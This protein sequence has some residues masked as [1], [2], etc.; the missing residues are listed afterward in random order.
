M[1]FSLFLLAVSLAQGGAPELLRVTGDT[2]PI[3]DPS[4][5]W[6]RGRYYI[7][8]TN[9][10]RGELVPAFCSPDLHEWRFCG[11]VFD[12]VPQWAMRAVPGASGIW[13]PDV[14]RVHGEFRLYYA[15]STFGSN[16]SVIGLTTNRTLNP[17]SPS[18]RWQ[19]QGA[20]IGSRATGDW[21]AIDPNAVVDHQG[22]C[23]LALG[24]FWSGI[25]LRRL[26]CATGK[27]SG[28]DGTLYALASR[29]ASKPAAVEAPFLIRHKSYYYLFVSFDLC[30]RG[31][32]STYRIMVGRAAHITGPYLD[33]TGNRML[34]G[35]GTELLRGNGTWAGPGGAS[36]LLHAGSF[37]DIVVFHAYNGQ[38]GRPALQISTISWTDGWPR[39]GPLPGTSP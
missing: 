18:Y 17:E 5:A 15:V 9:R 32:R 20:V 13:A 28:D 33:R 39:I 4:I 11:H 21:N 6:E 1:P 27:L 30:C 12:A 22:N 8:A 35:G 2:S 10:F 14:S 3:H 31:S 34:D 36:I 24:S 26:D 37:G 25:K 23:W 29:S 16:R 19:D 7:Y 38:T